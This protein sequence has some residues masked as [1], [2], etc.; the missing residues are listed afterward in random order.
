M[1]HDV[2]QC[3]VDTCS[4]IGAKAGGPR[5][6]HF[7]DGCRVDVDAA[8]AAF[9]LRSLRLRRSQEGSAPARLSV[10]EEVLSHQ[11]KHAEE[12]LRSASLDAIRKDDLAASRTQS[13]AMNEE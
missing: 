7:A 6:A 3:L 2:P 11:P 4:A 5:P 10:A 8:D 9:V 13:Q 1:N 12:C